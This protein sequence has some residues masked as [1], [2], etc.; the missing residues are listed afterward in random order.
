MTTSDNPRIP[1]GSIL[2]LRQFGGVVFGIRGRSTDVASPVDPEQH[3]FRGCDAGFVDFVG[4]PDIQGQ[5][6]LLL[7][8]K[9]IDVGF[10]PGF[11]SQ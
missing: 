9:Y 10:T 5:A 3:C 11:K 1:Q 7:P 8:G 4:R 2:L 6:V